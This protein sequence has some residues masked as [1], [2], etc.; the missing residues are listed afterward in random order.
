MR[1]VTYLP[2]VKYRIM[3]VPRRATYHVNQLRVDVSQL[4]TY[5]HVLYVNSRRYSFWNFNDV[6]YHS[7]RHQ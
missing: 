4:L 1:L 6:A 3:S 2:Y 7:A 5:V